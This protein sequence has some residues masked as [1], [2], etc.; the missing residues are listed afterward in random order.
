[1]TNLFLGENKYI[2]YK[3]KYTRNILK[4]VS[5]FSNFHDG[6]IIFGISDNKK[7]KGVK[8]IVE[9]KLNIE[10][11]INDSVYPKPFF[12]FEKHIEKG[13]NIL[14]LTVYK[15]DNTPYTYKNSA[16]M[17]SDTSTVKTDRIRYN[18]L[19]LYGQ[20]KTYDSL[21]SDNQNLT[22]DILSEKL[23]KNKN[24]KTFNDDLLKTLELKQN[25]IYNKAAQLLSDKNEISTINLIVYKDNTVKEIKDKKVLKNISVIEQLE[26]CMDFYNKHININEKIEG[27]YRQTIE[28]IPKVAYREA[29]ANA[30]VHRDYSIDSNIKIEFFKNRIEIYSPGSLPIGISEN[31]Y[32]EGRISVARN[33]IIADVFL[34]IGIIEKIATGI[35]RIKAY[36]QEYEVNPEFKVSKNSVL[37][38]LPKVTDEKYYNINYEALEVKEKEIYDLL[39]NNTVMKRKEIEDKIKLKKSQTNN[40]LNELREKDIVYKIGKGRSTRYKIK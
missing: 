12:E 34:R 14:I 35:R 7:I 30:I 31:E 8:N 29:V 4:T 10:N 1:M 6:K 26:K 23:S 37:I 32:K 24:I 28:E 2:E 5:A 27:I 25:E 3:E 9:L 21:K 17:R 38:V 22:F 13:K 11:A 19:I 16:Y 33:K 20:N 40:I 39:K 18:E 36:Y 15:G